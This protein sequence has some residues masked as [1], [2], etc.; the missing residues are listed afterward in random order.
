MI[1]DP[2]ACTKFITVQRSD[3]TPTLHWWSLPL[4]LRALSSI[5]SDQLNGAHAVV[6]PASAALAV[7]PGLE[8]VGDA[9]AAVAWVDDVATF[10]AACDD[11]RVAPCTIA[12]FPSSITRTQLAPRL[13]RFARDLE[14][15]PFTVAVR[16]EGG[17]RGRHRFCFRVPGKVVTAIE[18]VALGRGFGGSPGQIELALLQALALRPKQ[19][20]RLTLV[21]QDGGA[22]LEQTR[23]GGRRHVTW[24]V[25]GAGFVGQERER[26]WSDVARARFREDLRRFP[27]GRVMFVG[28]PFFIA[29]F[30]VATL[31]RRRRRAD[32]RD[33][34]SG[35]VEELS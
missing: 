29:S 26:A 21:L 13:A 20:A 34:G 19:Q 22:T 30:W 15:L 10:F 14:H 28:L 25:S 7:S 11:G 18:Q 35:D 16:P 12:V 2:V 8:V 27:V 3:L 32:V 9:D 31:L 4:P 33:A 1:L 5:A 24:L 17:G 6:H 23:T